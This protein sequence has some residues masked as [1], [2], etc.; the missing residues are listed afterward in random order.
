MDYVVSYVQNN[1]YK[2]GV[3][4]M[5]NNIISIAKSLIEDNS[6]GEMD[7]CKRELLFP[8][9]EELGYDIT[10]PL[11]IVKSPVYDMSG[12]ACDYGLVGSGNGEVYK[13]VIKVVPYGENFNNKKDFIEINE[14]FYLFPSISTAFIVN[15]YKFLLLVIYK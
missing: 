1:N 4:Y 7:I 15:K 6:I 14:V 2:K 12:E 5:L 9:I 10:L 3:L 11:E 13:F 8:F